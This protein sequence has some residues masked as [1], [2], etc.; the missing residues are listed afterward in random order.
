MKL[1]T[2]LFLSS[3]VL[4]NLK[5]NRNN[6]LPIFNLKSGFYNSYTIELTISI[7][8][9][10]ATIYYTMDGNYYLTI[11]IISTI[12]LINILFKIHIMF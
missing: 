2:F 10:K 3:L 12:L 8:D 4:A 1:F 7:E 6:Y 5:D 9:S 11:L